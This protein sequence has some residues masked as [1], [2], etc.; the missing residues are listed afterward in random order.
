M[1]NQRK[2]GKKLVGFFATEDEARALL[3]AADAA[4]MSVADW[5]RLQIREATQKP[6]KPRRGRKD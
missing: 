2:K 5:L 3:E 6:T 1:P 4:N